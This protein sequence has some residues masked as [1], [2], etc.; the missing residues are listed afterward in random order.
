MPHSSMAFMPSMDTTLGIGPLRSASS[1]AP[2]TR[3]NRAPPHSR[4]PPISAGKLREAENSTT[5]I[6]PPIK[7]DIRMIV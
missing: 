6:A 1:A 7:V 2:A 4:K 3:H 5:L